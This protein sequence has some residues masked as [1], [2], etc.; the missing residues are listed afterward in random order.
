M[1]LSPEIRARL[2]RHARASIASYLRGNDRKDDAEQWPDLP[3]CGVFVTL[4]KS[5]RLRGCIGVFEALDDLPTMIW[6]MAVSA[7]QDPRFVDMP[8]SPN[9]LSDVR[10]E[11]SLLSPLTRIDDPLGFQVGVHGIYVKQGHQVGCFLPDVASERGWDKQTFLTQCCQQKAGLTG[12]AWRAPG[13]EIFT[14][15]VDK[16]GD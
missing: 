14:F 15:T 8:L 13:T 12:D 1:E 3:R 10:I 2:L 11:I 4:R 6:R 5:G 9:E 7:S 16:F